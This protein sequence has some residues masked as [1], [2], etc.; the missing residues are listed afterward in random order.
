MPQW[1]AFDNPGNSG[2]SAG[3]VEDI[4]SSLS[5][6]FAGIVEDVEDVEDIE[7]SLSVNFAGIVEDIEDIESTLSVNFAE[8]DEVVFSDIFDISNWRNCRSF[9]RIA[10]N[11]WILANTRYWFCVKNPSLAHRAGVKGRK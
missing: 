4:E 11:F 9:A 2:R 6:N 3:I 8:I 1:S 7:S 5:V 10:E